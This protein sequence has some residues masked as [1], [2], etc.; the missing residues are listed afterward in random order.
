M[1]DAVVEEQ[2][3]DLMTIG[4]TTN[5]HGEVVA[6]E[7]GGMRRIDKLL[8][9]CESNFETTNPAQICFQGFGGTGWSRNSERP[10]RTDRSYSSCS[11]F[12]DPS[13]KDT[14]DDYNIHCAVVTLERY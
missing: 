9:R 14:R 6:E 12:K 2:T 3:F 4:P 13:L 7:W 1:L 8:F 11:Y 10:G 5:K